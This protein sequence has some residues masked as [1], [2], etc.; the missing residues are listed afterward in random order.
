MSTPAIQRIAERRVVFAPVAEGL[1]AL[2][3][4]GPVALLGSQRS[5]ALVDDAAFRGATVRRFD[6][7]R[8]HNPREVVD[9]AGALVDR[10]RCASVVAIGSSSAIDLGKAVSNGRDVVLALVPTALGGAEMSR[11]YGVL[12][13]DRKAGGRLQSPAPNLVYDAALLATLAPRELGS[14]GINGWAH[15]IEAHYARLQHALGTAAA[16]AAGSSFPALLL[17]AATARDEALLRALFVAAHQ[18]GFALEARSMGLHHAVCHVLGGLTQ[19]PHGIVNAIVLPHAIRTNTRIAF[20]A[21]AAVATAFGIADL[22]AEAERIAAAFSLPRSFRELGAPADL[23]ER[24]VPRVLEQ[25]LL[26]NN[27]ARPSEGDVTEL[28]RAV[29]G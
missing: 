1:G 24:A 21:V 6:G 11:G 17:R 18:S 29:Y 14:I 12:E 22:A 4:P 16:V 13:G 8:L 20:T 2:A 9:A 3:L 19:V 23:V 10:E 25:P 7:V 27:P 5:L 15:T 26:D 28:L